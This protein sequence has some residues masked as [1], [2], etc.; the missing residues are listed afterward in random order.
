MFLL[1]P[2]QMRLLDDLS[3]NKYNIPSLKLMERAGRSVVDVIQYK[4]SPLKDKHFVIFCGPGNNGGDGM[5]VARLL[6][7]KGAKI[8][9][10]ILGKKEQLKGDA[11][12]QL[13]KLPSG[14]SL[15]FIQNSVQFSVCLRQIPPKPVLIVDALFGTGLSRNVKGFSRK[16]IRWINRQKVPRLSADIPSGLNGETGQIL[17]VSVQADWTVT[18][19]FP[20]LGF[21]LGN[22]RDFVGELTVA[23]IGLSRKGINEIKSST[24]LITVEEIQPLLAL[25]SRQSHKG[26]FGHVFVIGGSEKKIGA[27]IMAAQTALLAGAG[28]STLICPANAFKKIDPKALE[29]MYE[30]INEWNIDQVLAILNKATIVALGPGLGLDFST[31]SFVR[32]LV[33]TYQG[34]LIIDADGLNALAEDPSVLKERRGALTLLTPHPAEMGRLT[35]MTTAEVQSDRLKIASSFAREYQVILLLKGYRS[36]LTFP[37]GHSWINPTGNPA[38]ASAGQGDVLTGIY[39]GLLAQF[40][41]KFEPNMIESCQATG[42]RAGGGGED[43]TYCP[44]VPLVFGCFLHGLVGDLLSG[45]VPGEKYQKPAK[46]VVMATDM[47][48]NL[49]LA[50]SFL[51]KKS[52]ILKTVFY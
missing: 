32:Q 19:G 37:D 46:R 2:N 45:I 42:G 20:K 48:H 11:A 22:A 41:G 4:F 5:V 12:Y 9:L 51:K 27:G 40:P 31:V 1:T 26:S 25:R 33:R 44:Y 17:G 18:F 39:A 50:Y 16:I 43:R 3:V 21:F 30:P 28:L 47:A 14:V 23:D 10:L 13:K 34:P 7:S 29:I 38:M 6:T 35:G 49:D 15:F 36:I 24:H 52:E 8:S